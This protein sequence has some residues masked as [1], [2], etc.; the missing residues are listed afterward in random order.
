MEK[1]SGKWRVLIRRKFTKTI[2]KTF[3]TKED[4]DKYA[5][6][7]ERQ[8]DKGFLVSYEEAQKTKL[9]A[10]LERYRAE[11]TS[12]KK[13]FPHVYKFFLDL[14]DARKFLFFKLRLLRTTK[15]FIA[16]QQK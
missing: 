3:V 10:L 14:K 16:K 12:K 6:E 7:T 11:I 4:A 5:R 1:R 2:S 8:I 9:G 15:L 13:G